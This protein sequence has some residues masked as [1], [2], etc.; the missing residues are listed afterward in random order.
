MIAALLR[1][2]SS[3]MDEPAFFEALYQIQLLLVEPR[4][5][6]VGVHFE[7]RLLPN[8][9]VTCYENMWYLEISRRWEEKILCLPRHT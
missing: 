9:V 6:R 8:N 2:T 4:I 3:T 7:P 1:I 5:V